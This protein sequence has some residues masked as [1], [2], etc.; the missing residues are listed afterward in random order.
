MRTIDKVILVSIA[1]LFFGPG[2][3]DLWTGKVG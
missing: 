3:Y 2:L 1:V